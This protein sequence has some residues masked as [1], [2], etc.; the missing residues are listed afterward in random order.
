[1]V[2]ACGGWLAQ[3]FPGIVSLRV[4]R[5]D[6]LFLR[7]GPA[8]SGVPAW[9]D[10]DM[11]M[12]GTGDID[13]LGV[14][15]APDREGPELGPDEPLPE[16][17]PANEAIAREYAALRFPELAQAPLAGSR[18]CRYELTADSQFVVGP[19]PGRPDVWVMGG[20]SGHGFKHGP[21]LAEMVASAIR[22]ESELPARFA[23]GE[24]QPGRSLRTAGSNAGPR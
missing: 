18:T 17:D 19:L 5:Q 8:W 23:V 20:G 4:T 11:A 12:Y 1:V 9:V 14:K 3:L 7:G 10:Y 13:G 24:R 2:W 22:G 21:A 6:L 16:V 15:L